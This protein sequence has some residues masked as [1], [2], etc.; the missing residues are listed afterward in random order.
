MANAV[1][2]N[3]LYVQLA[4]MS[5]L[6]ANVSSDSGRFIVDVEGHAEAKALLEDLRARAAQRSMALSKRLEAIAGETSADQD[7]S[8]APSFGRSDPDQPATTALQEIF[9]LLSQAI[10]GYTKLQTL[11]HRFRDSSALAPEG[12]ASHLAGAHVLDCVQTIREINRIL[13][14]VLVWELDRVG[15]ECICT[16]PSCS[17]GICLC[18]TASGTVLR[19]SG[20]VGEAPG[21]PSIFVQR[22]RQGSAAAEAGLQRGD[23]LLKADGKTVRPRSEL[24]ATIRDHAPGETVLLTVRRVSGGV[25]D[26]PI[27][28]PVF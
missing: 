10:V 18:A 9:L 22:P 17:S 8:D 23:L 19:E 24:Q 21:E 15:S 6:E 27:R 28:R 4:N 14:D 5:T 11:S 25:E 20:L 26:V 16:C 13:P 2:A 3:R 12:T 7:P 1:N